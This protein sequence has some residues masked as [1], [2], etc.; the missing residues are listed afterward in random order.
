MSSVAYRILWLSQLKKDVSFDSGS[1][2]I[3]SSLTVP[4]NPELS[5]TR[6]PAD[7]QWLLPL[8][9]W[10]LLAETRQHCFRFKPRNVLGGYQCNKLVHSPSPK[11]DYVKLINR[12]FESL[13][14]LWQKNHEIMFSK[15]ETHSCWFARLYRQKV[16]KVQ[17]WDSHFDAPQSCCHI[18]KNKR[19]FLSRY[20]K[21]SFNN[22]HMVKWNEFKSEM[23][24]CIAHYRTFTKSTLYLPNNS[25]QKV[26]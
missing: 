22:P 9:T 24:L 12:S 11:S 6:P 18:R 4:N 23:P 14:F 15:W 5:S 20:C 8:R 10:L 2:M 7:V 26:A 19:K 21:V 16:I 17:K 3:P 13:S 25:P 1:H